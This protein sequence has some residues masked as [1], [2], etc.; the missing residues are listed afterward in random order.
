MIGETNSTTTDPHAHCVKQTVDAEEGEQ[1]ECELGQLEKPFYRR[2]DIILTFRIRE[3]N[4][5]S[6]PC[7]R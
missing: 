3:T 4:G 2:C 7:E 1:D 5:K 6:I